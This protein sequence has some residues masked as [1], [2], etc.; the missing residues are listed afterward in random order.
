[1]LM[2]RDAMQSDANIESES[3]LILLLMLCDTNNSDIGGRSHTKNPVEAYVQHSLL[4]NNTAKH[5]H[6][7]KMAAYTLER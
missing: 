5:M 2:L 1:M 4:N 7:V 3:M 6:I